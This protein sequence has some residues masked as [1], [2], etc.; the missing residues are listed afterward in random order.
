MYVFESTVI[1]ELVRESA[2]TGKHC[3]LGKKSVRSEG[4]G[5][6]FADLHDL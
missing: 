6:I 2:E 3:V 4:D 1:V 5:G